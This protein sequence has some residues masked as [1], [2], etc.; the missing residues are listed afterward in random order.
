MLAEH[1]PDGSFGFIVNKPARIKLSKVT[2]EFEH[3]ESELFL[4]GP[5]QVNTL[6][7]V[8]TKGN[9]VKGSLKIIDGVY[10]GGDME[11]LHKL[12]LEGKMNTKDIRFYAGYAGW[13]PMQL[14]NEM[15][16]NSWII[17]EGKQNY[18]FGNQPYSLW[19]KIVLSL[20]HD[21]AP[22]VNFHPDPTLN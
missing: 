1:C 16:E 12:M 10:W 19:K 17:L 2:K 8:H 14:E 3:F 4:G 18:V 13:Q 11:L 5:V 21:Y 15:K 22:W 20:G 7:F 6:F 9:L